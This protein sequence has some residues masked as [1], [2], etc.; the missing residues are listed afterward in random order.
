MSLG[1][2]RSIAWI[3]LAPPIA[4]FLLLVA[5]PMFILV[6]MG[7]SYPAKG[8]V[9]GEGFSIQNYIDIFTTPLFLNSLLVTL[10][11]GVLTAVFALLLGFPL[12][13]FIWRGKGLLARV[14]ILI[15]LAP[16]LIS[17]IVRTYGWIVLLSNRGL[18][19][20]LLMYVGITDSPIRLVFNETGVVI[21]TVHVLLPFMVLSILSSLQA[22]DG[23]LEDAAATLG[24]K[25]WRTFRDVIFPLALPG[26]M[27]G[28]ILVF[29]LAV[30]SFITPVLLGGQLVMTI[31]VL[32]LQQF[33]TTFNWALGSALVTVLLV[34]VLAS[35]VAFEKVMQKNSQRGALP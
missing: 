12:A 9:F 15:T 24:A 21:G 3:L 25:P 23:A 11:V 28:L 30:G 8:R 13:M 10:R 29:I 1:Q 32:A 22:I 16:I 6:R 2:N 33:T 18:I 5:F 27:A 31:P 26:A 20:S 7:F 35:I 34:A 14:V 4:Y 17:A 19:N